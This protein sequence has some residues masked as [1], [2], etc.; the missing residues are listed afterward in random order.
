M[1]IVSDKSSQSPPLLCTL[2]KMA[3]K[4]AKIWFNLAIISKSIY[5]VLPPVVPRRQ[6][7]VMDPT[8]QCWTRAFKPNLTV[9]KA[10]RIRRCH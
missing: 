2:R 6:A 9:N 4:L 1:E 3:N 7:T 5:F 10:F 8:L